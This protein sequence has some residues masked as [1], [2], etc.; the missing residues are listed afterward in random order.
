MKAALV[1][2]VLACAL[3]LASSDLVCGSKYCKQNPCSAPTITS[4]KCR[5]PAVYRPNHAGKCACCPACV[6]LLCKYHQ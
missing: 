5:S 2:F 1:L 6:T 4:N 3:A